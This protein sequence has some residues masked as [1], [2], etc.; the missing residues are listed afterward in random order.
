MCLLIVTL[1][2]VDPL[3]TSLAVRSRRDHNYGYYSRSA[4]RVPGTVVSTLYALIHFI[5]PAA[6]CSGVQHGNR[7]CLTSVCWTNGYFRWHPTSQRRERSLQE[8]GLGPKG[9]STSSSHFDSNLSDLTKKNVLYQTEI[10][11]W[12]QLL[13][14]LE[15]RTWWT[16]D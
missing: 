16:R 3:H 10:K 11:P 6:L 5:F 4:E 14:S 8:L 15:W 13:C 9:G 7:R 1:P 2:G 12:V